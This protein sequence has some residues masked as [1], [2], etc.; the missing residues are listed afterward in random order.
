M[1]SNSGDDVIL[2]LRAAHDN[3]NNGVIRLIGDVFAEYPGV[4]LLVDEELPDLNSPATAF[5]EKNGEF[6]V[7]ERE[8]EI[9][10][11][12]AYSID[13]NRMSAE[14]CR[15]YVQKKCRKEGLGGELVAHVE[16]IVKRKHAQSLELWTDILFKDAHR[17]YQRLGYSKQRETRALGDVSCTIEFQF[18]KKF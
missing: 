6:F 17:F 1:P 16:R 8:K 12:V 18:V 14:L 13:S 2:G 15:L 9:V 7:V 3:D 10:A 5:K 11:C 4:I